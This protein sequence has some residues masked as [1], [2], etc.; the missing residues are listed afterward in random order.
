MSL[1]SRQPGNLM[2]LLNY[3]VNSL[4]NIKMFKTLNNF[5]ARI[6]QR[7]KMETV[8]ETHRLM[9]CYLWSKMTIQRVAD[10]FAC[11]K[12]RTPNDQHVLLMGRFTMQRQSACYLCLNN[13]SRADTQLPPFTDL[14][15]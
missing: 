5:F 9:K 4:R 10:Q 13:L 15:V 14:S 3:Q 2:D 7:N 11:I 6:S 12:Q 8:Q 1:G